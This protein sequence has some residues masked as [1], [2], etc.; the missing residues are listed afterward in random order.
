VYLEVTCADVLQTQIWNRIVNGFDLRPFTNSTLHFLGAYPYQATFEEGAT[1]MTAVAGDDF[2]GG[3]R[4]LIVATDPG[5][6][7]GDV[8]N[9]EAWGICLV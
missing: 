5:N 6:L 8:N 9:D 3:P 2:Y 4:K 7:A 1:T